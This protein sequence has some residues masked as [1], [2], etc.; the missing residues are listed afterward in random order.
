MTYLSIYPLV[1][2]LLTIYVKRYVIKHYSSFMHS[3]LS[4]HNVKI[5]YLI[6]RSRGLTDNITVTIIN[7]TIHNL[8]DTKFTFR[9]PLG[10]CAFDYN[11][12]SLIYPYVSLFELRPPSYLQAKKILSISSK[13]FF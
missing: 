11:I 1:L 13:T 6:S 7:N 4:R 9:A 10:L 8:E 3:R 12:F 2:I 5:Q